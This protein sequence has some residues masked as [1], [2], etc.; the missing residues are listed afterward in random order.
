MSNERPLLQLQRRGGRDNSPTL[1]SQPPP[2]PPST[3]VTGQLC[4][5]GV[6]GLSQAGVTATHPPTGRELQGEK[7]RLR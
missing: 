5:P 2:Q 7:L 4:V 1:L 3:A 6:W